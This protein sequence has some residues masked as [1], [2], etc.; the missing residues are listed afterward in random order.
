MQP[1]TSLITPRAACQPEFAVICAGIVLILAQKTNAALVSTASGVLSEFIA[2]VY[3]YNKTVV[4]MASYHQK[5][6]DYQKYIAG[7]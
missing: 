6:R 5:T 3:L 2:A 7:A 4:S 1:I